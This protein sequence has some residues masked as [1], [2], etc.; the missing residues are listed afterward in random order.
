M[1]KFSDITAEILIKFIQQTIKGSDAKD[2]DVFVRDGEIIIA[3]RETGSGD[4]IR[5][6]EIMY[7]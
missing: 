3:N 2:F 6:D 4:G 1:K 7:R 5:A